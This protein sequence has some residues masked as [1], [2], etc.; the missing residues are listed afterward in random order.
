MLVEK[1]MQKPVL[2]IS[3]EVPVY[4]AL[5]LVRDRNIR[6]LP[7]VDGSGLVG[8]VSDR[9]LRDA[10]PSCLEHGNMQILQNTPV[11]SIMRTKVITI[12]PLDFVDEAVKLI[13]QHKI[14]CL[15]VVSRGQVVG[16]VS[17]TDLLNHLVDMFG[18]LQPGSYLE[19]DIPDRP[20]VLAEIATIIK[21]H[22]VNVSSVLLC[23][24]ASG[25]KCLVMRIQALNISKILQDIEQAG[26][27][28]SWPVSTGG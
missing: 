26:Y 13:Y 24:G 5:Q 9:D 10:C 21:E 1:V 8:I 16:I 18:L 11:Q 6:H 25:R 15:P 23:P 2:T 7:V 17:E 27:R 14:G 28:I 12:H 3:P 22:E 4:E 20:G 19:V